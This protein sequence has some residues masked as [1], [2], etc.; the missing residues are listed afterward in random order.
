MFLRLPEH[1]LEILVRIADLLRFHE[2]IKVL[3]PYERISL[4]SDLYPY[5]EN[6]D[7]GR[8]TNMYKRYADEVLTCF[9][10]KS[11]PELLETMKQVLL[12]EDEIGNK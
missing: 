7:L 1:S 5:S 8:I 9:R 12:P 6:L 11:A 2:A 10:R 3:S 4:F